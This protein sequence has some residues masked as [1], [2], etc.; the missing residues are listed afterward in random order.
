MFLQALNVALR[1]LVFRAGPQDFP[2]SPPLTQAVVPLAVLANY[3]VFAQVLPPLM[4][5][6]MALAAVAGMALV[7]RGLL[8]A[9]QLEN[10]SNQT[11][12]A[13]LLCSA[14][15]TAALALPFSQV[16]PALLH[17][18]QNP[19]LIND[20]QALQMPQGPAFLMN[21]LNVWNF[22][23]TVFIFRSSAN[24]GTGMG[25]LI[26]VFAALAVGLLVIVCGSF[27][28]A[29]LGGAASE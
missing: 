6:V 20:P 10:R 22:A 8:R 21:L 15:L 24:I 16:A 14:L 5:V 28:G 11:I 23:V 26:A 13:L 17:L 19:E 7:T 2:Y 12:N 29:L 27:A 18:A 25:L 4:S 1:V 9:R 3:L